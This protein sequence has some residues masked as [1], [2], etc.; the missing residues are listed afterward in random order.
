M[1]KTAIPISMNTLMDEANLPRFL[2][3]VRQCGSERVF[4][5]GMG[6][7]Y[8]KT[9]RNY[10]HADAIRRA[11]DYFHAAGLEVGIWISAFGHGHA[12]MPE[13]TRIDDAVKYTQ[14]T[15]ISGASGEQYSNCPLDKNFIRDY[16]EGVRRIA[17]FSIDLIM[18][19]DDFRF[20][21][22]RNNHFACFCPLHLA[23]YYR[24]I[25]GEIP[26]EQLEMLL[27]TGKN[28]KYR[29]ELF[30]LFRDSLLDFIKA[31]R[32][33]IDE[34]NPDIRLGCCDCQTWDMHGTDPIEIAKTAAGKNKPFAR[35]LGA[36]YIN[37]NI[38]PIIEVSR[39]Q[40]AWGKNSGVE[41][42]AE[43]DTY[44][45]P[46]HNVPSKTLE[47]FDFIMRADGTADGMLMYLEDYSCA[48]DYER[49]YV[50][51][52]VR[53]QPIRDGIAAL[54]G[55]K[56]PVGVQVFTVPH[57]AENW[58]LGDTLQPYAASMLLQAQGA[59]SRDLLSSN[60]I[61][62]GFAE[63]GEYPVLLIGENARYIDP[64]KLHR[65]AILDVPAA[66]ILASRGIDTGL[67]EAVPGGAVS[68]YYISRSSGMNSIDSAALFHIKCKDGALVQSVLRPSETPA[69]YRY[70]NADG[71]RF[72]V[73][74][75]DMY[76]SWCVGIG[77]NFLKSYYRQA[78]LVSAIEWMAG[79]PLPAFSAKHPNLYIL[80]SKGKDAMSVAL[81]NVYLD[82]V[83]SPE[84]R[85]DKTYSEIRFLN[86][87]GRLDGDTVYLSDI[88]P[89][90][91]MAFEVK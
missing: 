44:P 69:S 56:T 78:D 22:R 6:N 74:A 11:V 91:F 34:V 24:R 5:C 58:E 7:I 27:L 84:I 3:D 79:K 32:R 57:K 29:R 17:E 54:F 68:E 55:D 61:P 83:F 25:G 37:P 30:G 64:A 20:D 89:Y 33:T 28:S 41:L 2:E 63:N 19:D 15:D 90:G 40:F 67:I 72:Y 86:C 45:R 1:Y 39:Q 10:T 77:Q 38:I 51:R 71:Q 70:E 75:F 14:I 73:L 48:Y 46:R 52:Y 82:D 65:G 43:G 13:Q 36:P 18:L 81:A 80:A 47:L 88:P 8:M 53:N 49:G 85:L 50:E 60:S 16:C 87:T 76:K 66:K 23:E 35:I 31:I 9:G 26:R 62:T 42:F 4:I 21:N 59:P 12:L